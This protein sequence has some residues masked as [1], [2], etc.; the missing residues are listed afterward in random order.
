MN[1]P[2]TACLEAWPDLAAHGGLDPELPPLPLRRDG[3]VVRFGD[4]VLKHVPERFG[5]AVRAHR[6]AAR[7]LRDHPTDTAV[8]FMGFDEAR[9]VLMVSFAPGSSLATLAAEGHDPE[10]LCAL[11]G[12]WLGTFHRAR[13]IK[14]APFGARTPLTFVPEQAAY[15]SEA[16]EVLRAQ[17]AEQAADL[18]GTEQ[19]QAVLHGDMNATNLIVDGDLCTGIDFENLSHHPAMRD[20]GQVLAALRLRCDSDEKAVLPAA[21]RAAFEK[22]YGP[23]GPLLDFFVLQ[24]VLMPWAQMPSHPDLLGPNRRAI[25]DRLAWLA[26]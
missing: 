19:A 24:R 16:F 23:C 22:G 11:V 20:A 18:D 13:E 15:L 6:Q 7:L 2:F 17:L 12:R 9:S 5:R 14:S 1:F 3:S 25:A 8:R 26:Q 10:H 4:V 21:W